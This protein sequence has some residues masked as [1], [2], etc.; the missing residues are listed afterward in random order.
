MP[1]VD[2]HVREVGREVRDFAALHLQLARAEARQGSKH[3]LSSLF[4]LAFGVATF[5]LVLVAAGVALFL[6][7]AGVM[8]PAAAAALVAAGYLLV[9]V[10]AWWAG[11]RLMQGADA[12]FLPQTRTLLSELITCRDEPMNSP[13]GSGPAART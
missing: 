3:L 8:P 13:P 7:L 10:A 2:E 9:G 1:I 11:W 5:S 4:L 6:L 12:L